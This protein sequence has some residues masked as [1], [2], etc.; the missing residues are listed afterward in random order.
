MLGV[1]QLRP[2]NGKNQNVGSGLCRG[3]QLSPRGIQSAG[4]RAVSFYFQLY[5]K[6]SGGKVL[7]KTFL[8][9]EIPQKTVGP[10]DQG[11]VPENAAHS[12]L[13][14]VL[15]VSAVTPLE[16]QHGQSVIALPQQ[17]GDLK[18]RGAVG[19][20]AVPGKFPVDPEI[21]TGIHPFKVQKPSAAFS[22]GK[23]ALLQVKMT[24][25]E[26]A[27]IFLRHI[28][29]VA[30]N[31]VIY[32]GVLVPAIAVVLPAGGHG[33][34]IHFLLVKKDALFRIHR[35]LI[36][37]KV[38]EAPGPVQGKHPGGQALLRFFNIR[39][40][41]VIASVWGGSHMENVGVFMEMPGM[42]FHSAASFPEAKGRL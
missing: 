38:V 23:A 33:D 12:Q 14:L 36:A 35:V 21:Q 32:I 4:N 19:N 8:Y 22:I 28:G 27:G 9:K 40:G 7:G 1:P 15:Q 30:G 18:F 17:L 25:I 6:L 26:A 13:I 2:L 37:F 20:L 29:R 39:E 41:N 34:R 11:N 24:D 5:P 10:G 31:G 3:D 42:L 16:Y